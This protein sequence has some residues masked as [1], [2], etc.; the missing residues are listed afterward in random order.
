MKSKYWPKARKI[1]IILGL[2]YLIAGILLYFFQ[3]LL[4][5]HPVP[6]K[7]E[8]SYHFSLPF[9]ELNFKVGE[10]NLN[11]VKFKPE[12]EAK[13]LVIFF[14]GNMKNVE[15]YKNYPAYFTQRNYEVWIP[16]YPGFGKSTGERT[17]ENFYR[18][19]RTI[20]DSATKANHSENVII[21][22]KSIGTGV[23]AYLA[24]VKPCKRLILETPYYSI[25]AL[26]KS[27]VPFYPVALMARYSFPVY[28]F[29]NQSDASVTI[30]HGTKDEVVPYY[31]SVRL[32]IENKR[33]ELV[34]IENGR[35]N[36]LSSFP[37]YQ[38][39]LDSLLR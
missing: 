13:G 32:S 9:E 7:M 25:E 27:F 35:H 12:G 33:T 20:Y 34:R 29:I 14:H 4:L 18:D 31:H 37:L 5:F 19:A 39:K 22:G 28:Q 15:H 16:D 8:E 26:A 24:S 6:K 36:N 23:A 10:R 2:I 3:D 11:L 38:H 1:L 30:F 21:Y 17:E